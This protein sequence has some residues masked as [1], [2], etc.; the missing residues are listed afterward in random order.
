[1]VEMNDISAYVDINSVTM[2]IFCINAANALNGVRNEGVLL[3]KQLSFKAP[4][5]KVLIV[6]DTSTNLRVSKELISL[7]GLEVHVCKS[8]PEA[9]TL[10][11]TNQYDII[12]MDHMMPGMDGIEAAALIRAIDPGSEYYRNLPIIALTANAISGQREM[13]LKNGMNDFLAKPIDLQKLDAILQKW[14]LRKKQVNVDVECE[15]SAQTVPAEMFEIPGVSVETGLANAGGSVRAYEDILDIF[16]TDAEEKLDQ[17]EKCVIT[18]DFNL[19][20]TLAH[21]FKGASRGIG[22][23]EF[24]DFA[25]QME[26][27][28]R[29]GDAGVIAEETGAFLASAREL[30]DNIRN[31]LKRANASRKQE[32]EDLTQLQMETLRSALADMDIVT[33]NK[34]ILEYASLPLSD[35]ARKI[36]TN[37]ENH[38][39]LFDY[40]KAIEKIDASR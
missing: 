23:M 6:D 28:A 40:D 39:L 34:L 3:K 8:G 27:A 20:M 2:P 19:Y 22:A 30:A 9:I 10:A 24:G 36:L 33:T 35:D 21:A 11:Q 29:A 7:Y 31:S 37:I 26:T 38:I 15:T 17:L 25:A 13:F 1:M 5:A 32:G 18:G 4:D 14:I 16:C 12:F